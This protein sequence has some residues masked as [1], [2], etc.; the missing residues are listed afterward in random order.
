MTKVATALG[1][2]MPWHPEK[3]MQIFLRESHRQ[4]RPEDFHR[5][6][7]LIVNSR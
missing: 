2:Y 3:Q 4:L 5:L 6:V 7:S 1:W